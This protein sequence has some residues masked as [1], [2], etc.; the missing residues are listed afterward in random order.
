MTPIVPLAEPGIGLR[1]NRPNDATIAARIYEPHR[2]DAIRAPRP[3]VERDG[4]PV[5]MTLVALRTRLP[6]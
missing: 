1:A 6:G 3:Q 5:L 2:F 4:R